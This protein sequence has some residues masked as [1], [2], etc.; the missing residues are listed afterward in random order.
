MDIG[1]PG[2]FS[3]V[4]V[5]V[6]GFI[7]MI[8]RDAPSVLRFDP[9]DQEWPQ[10]MRDD[11]AAGKLSA[12][13]STNVEVLGSAGVLGEGK[14]CGAALAADGCL[15][16]MP[17]HASEVLRVDTNPHVP[18]EE[19][20]QLI[21]S[22]YRGHAKWHGCAL[23]SDGCVYG[24]PS[25]ASRVLRVDPATRSTT[26]IGPEY[27]GEYKWIGACVGPDGIIISMVDRSSDGILVINPAAQTVV[28]SKAHYAFR[29]TRIMATYLSAAL[30]PDGNIYAP[31]GGAWHALEYNPATGTATEVG[32][33]LGMGFMKYSNA[34]VAADGKLYAT[35]LFARKVLQI[36]PGTKQV[37]SIGPPHG[38]L[39]GLGGSVI[40]KYEG[41][42]IGFDGRIW[43][44]PNML[45]HALVM[46]PD[47]RSNPDEYW[48]RQISFAFSVVRKH[49]AKRRDAVGCTEPTKDD[50]AFSLG[51]LLLPVPNLLAR[52]LAHDAIQADEELLIA[53]L[54]LKGFRLKLLL[55]T[56]GAISNWLFAGLR[57]SSP[58]TLT[59]FESLSAAIDDA[60][61]ADAGDGEGRQRQ[62]M[63]PTLSITAVDHG[64]G[65]FD[66]ANMRL[67]YLAS[68]SH[69]VLD[70]MP[71]WL[72][73]DRTTNP[74]TG[75]EGLV[76]ELNVTSDGWPSGVYS[77]RGFVEQ[78]HHDQW[79]RMSAWVYFEERVPARTSSFG[80]KIQGT[81]H[82]EW[83]AS[84]RPNTWTLVCA[85]CKSRP[86]YDGDRHV[87]IF[88]SVVGP[89]RVR[90]T[91][92]KFELFEQQPP[93]LMSAPTPRDTVDA[94]AAIDIATP[95]A[96]VDPVERI[97]DWLAS[98]RA[99][100]VAPP[101]SERER[102]Y[103]PL[104][105]SHAPSWSD[106]GSHQPV[107]V[108]VPRETIISTMLDQ[109]SA[110]LRHELLGLTCIQLVM[111]REQSIG[112]WLVSRLGGEDQEQ[113]AAVEYVERLSSLPMPNERRA[114]VEA[115]M[116]SLRGL[117]PAT[118]GLNDRRTERVVKTELIV[119]VL[120][121]KLTQPLTMAVLIADGLV[122]FL[123][124]SVTMPLWPRVLAY[125]GPLSFTDTALV[126]ATVV[127][128]AY[129][130]L[131]E[132]MQVE[133]RPWL[134]CHPRA[135]CPRLAVRLNVCLVGVRAGLQYAQARPGARH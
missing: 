13:P 82:N 110:Q 89:Q 11:E 57:R 64:L 29:P 14:W 121:S 76:Y 35:P 16:C 58:V 87:L 1:S 40:P 34:V 104:L 69:D 83:V 32:G 44:A 38:A 119:A 114:K 90:F 9:A 96:A 53:L 112:S 52:L 31:P 28:T 70:G 25:C 67:K 42:A 65:S 36:D 91:K 7:Y 48:H 131:R 98:L 51:A 127:L 63:A 6:D 81:L 128:D 54:K 99:T 18:R 101:L 45:P 108:Q 24:I 129:V 41:S 84:V 95:A 4:V 85:I 26:L 22:S 134:L 92:L 19:R 117:L 94:D 33:T 47:K 55:E 2:Q 15:Y 23:G 68:L 62:A 59:Y 43:C 73:E 3:T 86:G 17:C 75:T 12:L 79:V 113:E 66:L 106:V 88:D 132:V 71:E 21:G 8:P 80:F 111:S 93:P 124:L 20:C 133:S 74:A 118:L 122:L 61:E 50:L 107:Q 97:V 46:E 100:S 49:H 72:K 135:V 37:R 125:N 115:R 60:A 10:R 116:A 130:L 102:D 123:L 78:T 30:A 5:G 105:T 56:S 77:W 39:A 126:I 120:D 109:P 27:S 103:P